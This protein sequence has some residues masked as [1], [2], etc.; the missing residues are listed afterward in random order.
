MSHQTYANALSPLHVNEAPTSPTQRTDNREGNRTK[1]RTPT[2]HAACSFLSVRT[3]P[4]DDKWNDTERS[5]NKPSPK[6]SSL[7]P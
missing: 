2:G 1:N 5:D 7:A 6:P 4:D 3:E